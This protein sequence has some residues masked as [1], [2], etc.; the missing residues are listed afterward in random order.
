MGKIAEFTYD[1]LL[2]S[3]SHTIRVIQDTTH[4]GIKAGTEVFR[5]FYKDEFNIGIANTWNT[6]DATI[7]KTLVDTA[8]QFVTGRSG[9]LFNSMARSAIDGVL[10]NAGDMSP[11]AQ[12]MLSNMRDGLKKISN[13]QEAA[14]YTADDFYKSFKGTTVTFPASLTV[15]LV[16]DEFN[17]DIDIYDKVKDII[18]VSMGDTETLFDYVG[19]QLAPNGFKSG[20]YNLNNVVSEGTLSL[21]YGDRDKVISTRTSSNESRVDESLKLKVELSNYYDSQIKDVMERIREVESRVDLDGSYSNLQSLNEELN[22]LNNRRLGID[23]EVSEIIKDRYGELDTEFDSVANIAGG[24]ASGGRVGFSL[25]KMVVSSLNITL[26][27]TNVEILY[28]HYRPLYIDIQM[29]FEPAT[30]YTKT[31]IFKT[32]DLE[33]KLKNRLTTVRTIYGGTSSQ[34]L[35]FTNI[36]SKHRLNV[37]PSYASSA[38]TT[39]DLI[40]GK[41]PMSEIEYEALTDEV[42]GR[43]FKEAYSELSPEAKVQFLRK[44][45]YQ[46]NPSLASSVWIT[47]D[48]SGRLVISSSSGDVDNN[49]DLAKSIRESLNSE[50]PGL[51]HNEVRLIDNSSLH[52]VEILSPI[53]KDRKREEYEYIESTID[54][55]DIIENTRFSKV[56]SLSKLLDP[57]VDI[58]E[59]PTNLEEVPVIKLS[60]TDKYYNYVKSVKPGDPVKTFNDWK[61]DKNFRKLGISTETIKAPTPISG[62]SIT[63]PPT[64]SPLEKDS[65]VSKELY[66]LINKKSSNVQWK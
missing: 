21:I 12:G 26:S 55:S 10:N 61:L 37:S 22:S 19:I 53:H 30:K 54:S 38:K 50:L 29:T 13:Y 4:K 52:S 6:G 23:N 16:S 51:D 5:T 2:K 28:G 3:D 35:R 34:L 25:H 7:V 39:M 65:L 40:T 66:N 63:L 47:T 11:K 44:T 62:N 43:Y 58:D 60:E 27:K 1:Y 20:D 36:A 31:D 57:K 24:V 45:L 59:L 9:K 15:T 49:S 8:A 56:S 32:L 64:S 46:K 33:N 14:Y 42:K 17:P 41:Y 48:T 18:N